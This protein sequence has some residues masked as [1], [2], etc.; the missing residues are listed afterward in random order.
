MSI[1]KGLRAVELGQLRVGVKVAGVRWLNLYLLKFSRSSMLCRS[2]FDAVK[3][4]SHTFS[5]LEDLNPVV[6]AALV[7]LSGHEVS[8]ARQV[9]IVYR[10]RN[11]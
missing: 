5:E 9:H 11:T 2:V 3:A 1:K 4:G 10:V 6:T 7:R 8:R